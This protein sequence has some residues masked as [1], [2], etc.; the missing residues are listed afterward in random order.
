M[1]GDKLD[2]HFIS[3]KAHKYCA[4]LLCVLAK[5]TEKHSQHHNLALVYWLTSHCNALARAMY[6]TVVTRIIL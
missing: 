4:D 3:K 2:I 5:F 6:A 1:G